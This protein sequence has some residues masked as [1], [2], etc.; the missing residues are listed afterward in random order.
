MHNRHLTVFQKSLGMRLQTFVSSHQVGISTSWRYRS[1]ILPSVAFN[2]PGIMHG[3]WGLPITMTFSVSSWRLLSQQS[4]DQA[5]TKITSTLNIVRDVRGNL[6][7]AN[8]KCFRI[9]NFLK[10]FCDVMHSMANIN[11]CCMQNI[12]YKLNTHKNSH[13]FKTN[14]Y[15]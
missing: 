11:T 1:A 2:K 7:S 3:E 4:A 6:A 14:S 10:R 15:M 13:I 12:Q 5:I 9:I 8:L